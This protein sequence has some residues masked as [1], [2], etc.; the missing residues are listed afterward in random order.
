M[1]IYRS[2]YGTEELTG[3]AL[4]RAI[5]AEMG[6]VVFPTSSASS[7]F[8]MMKLGLNIAFI[9]KYKD[10]GFGYFNPNEFLEDVLDSGYLD[11]AHPL[12]VKRLTD[13]LRYYT[14]R[15]SRFIDTL[16]YIG[17]CANTFENAFINVYK[18][19]LDKMF[20]FEGE[21]ITHMLKL[22]DNICGQFHV[23]NLLS[24]CDMFLSKWKGNKK[25]ESSKTY[26]YI[27]KVR[28]F[29][30]SIKNSSSTETIDP[31]LIEPSKCM[32]IVIE[33]ARNSKRESQ[34]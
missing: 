23:I 26:K 7:V 12:F 5:E 6:D 2:R 11:R 34:K 33:S 29:L 31:S 27:V 19:D 25:R 18:H 14:S 9:A 20:R 13:N 10:I 4:E 28:D 24:E 32:K 22:N 17:R 15:Y 1:K 30:K 3:V 8:Y 16:I 21:K